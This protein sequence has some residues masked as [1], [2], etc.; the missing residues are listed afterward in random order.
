MLSFKQYQAIEAHFTHETV[1]E[2]AK[3]VDI[4]PST[5]IAWRKK[6]EF[7]AVLEEQKREFEKTYLRKLARLAVKS[8]RNLEKLIDNGSE[9]SIHKVN[10]IFLKSKAMDDAD[11]IR[12]RLKE[13]ERIADEKEHVSPVALEPNN[14]VRTTS[15]I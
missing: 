2:I 6:P 15:D 11:E 4:S 14:E 13:L 9:S 3:A 12:R 7:I 10:D 1:R 8:L 5:V